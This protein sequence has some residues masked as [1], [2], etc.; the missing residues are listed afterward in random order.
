VRVI[1]R[2]WRAFAT[3]REL[4]NP[5]RYKF[6]AIQFFS[7][8]I[9]RYLVVF[10]LLILLLISPLL[11]KTG[12]IYQMATIAQAAFYSCALLGLLLNRTRF[13]QK[14]VFTI[15][16]LFLHGQRGFIGRHNLRVAW[17][18]NQ[19]LGAAAS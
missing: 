7:H 14:K 6:Y 11:W 16:I 4:L 9:L 3:V 13:G 1:V 17:A 15:H 19:A 2:S 12:F 8:K 10:P 5:F 18:P